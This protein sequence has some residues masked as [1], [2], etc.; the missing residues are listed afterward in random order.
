MWMLLLGM[1]T[2]IAV[3]RGRDL[4]IDI[5]AGAY[6]ATVELAGVVAGRSRARWSRA[7]DDACQRR[8]RRWVRRG[9]SSERVAAARAEGQEVLVTIQERIR[10]V[11]GL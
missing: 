10:E 8:E 7:V 6:I 4:L 5:A 11:R 9:I 3:V 1:G 2:G